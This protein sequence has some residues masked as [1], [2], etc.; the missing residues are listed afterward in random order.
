MVYRRT[1]IMLTT[2]VALF[3]SACGGSDSAD[4]S[5]PGGSAEEFTE[6]T[7]LSVPDIS[8]TVTFAAVERGFFL[9]H[10]LDVNLRLLSSGADIVKGLQAGEAQFGQ[11]ATTSVPVARSSGLNL[12]MVV[13]IMN[14]ATSAKF[15]GNLSIIARAD[16]GIDPNDP[17]SLEGKKIAVLEGST[18][19][20]YL[21]AYL[22]ENGSSLDKVDLLNLAVPDQPIALKQGEV[23]AITPWEPFVSQVIREMGDDAIIVSRGDALIGYV[24]GIGATDEVIE[25]N[26]DVIQS[27][28]D[29][30]S[31][32]AQWVRQNPD[33]AARVTGSYIDGLNLVDATTAIIE[34]VAFD[35]RISDCTLEAFEVQAQALF[36]AGVT[37]QEYGA[38]ELVD[39]SFSNRSFEVYPELFE[40]LG[41]VSHC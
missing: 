33:E 2:A 15:A 32:A 28:T 16:S 8:G 10:G 9:K 5:A 17:S 23:D 29:A 7:L 21:R 1:L 6:V 19:Q 31:E 25:E 12:R 27:F 35:P 24:I 36:D 4:G 20:S 38:E 14:D 11:V 39:P 34:H 22:E 40:D 18:P 41:S 30:I 26:P 37:T 13:P 3:A